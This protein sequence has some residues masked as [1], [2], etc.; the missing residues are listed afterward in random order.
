M[1]ISNFEKLTIW[2]YSDEKGITEISGGYEEITG[3]SEE[4]FKKRNKLWHQFVHPDDKLYFERAMK[5]L[6]KKQKGKVDVE[7]RIIRKD[8]MIRNVVGTVRKEKQDGD[9]I[10][11]G[12]VVDVTKEPKDLSLK[13]HKRGL[14]NL[15]QYS[16]DILFNT[17]T[18]RNER[19]NRILQTL[20]ELVQA[21]RTYIFD[22][23][24][25]ND[26]RPVL[27]MINE[28]CARGITEKINDDIVK[29]TNL[30]E[31]SRGWYE[32]L[33]IKKEEISGPVRMF[34]DHERQIL[35]HRNVKSLLLVPIWYNNFFQG[36]I[37]FD[38]CENERYWTNQ[39]IQLLGAFGLLI[40]ASWHYEK[41]LISVERKVE[42]LSNLRDEQESFLRMLSHQLKTPISTIDINAEMLKQAYPDK[43]Q[44]D[45]KFI[46]RIERI[47]KSTD[48]LKE[49]IDSI[50]M[51]EPAK[52]GSFQ[53]N[54]QILEDVIF[55]ELKN[56]QIDESNEVQ[57]YKDENSIDKEIVIP[58]SSKKLNYIF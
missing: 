25:Q 22:N 5:S 42:E 38:D 31:N 12:Y 49:L 34:A 47:K 14:S 8:G 26:H 48:K 29:E 30:Y 1:K 15:L 32:S 17:E 54:S 39:E 58:I 9:V 57:L 24:N 53:L 45:S 41:A 3:Y 20:G 11:K 10:F 46:G 37:G 43:E 36:L 28:W 23:I 52:E 55:R 6:E 51:G 7:Y 16:I 44:K 27:S 33:V 21:D 35:E 18:D 2:S 50:I 13:D 4:D 40:W 56:Q 19:V